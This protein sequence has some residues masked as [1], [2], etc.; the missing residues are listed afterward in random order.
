MTVFIKSKT[1]EL[2]GDN[3]NVDIYQLS[4]TCP[5]GISSC[6]GIITLDITSDNATIQINQKD[7]TNDS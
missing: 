1:V 7:T 3:A 6:K 5:T 4:G 2:N